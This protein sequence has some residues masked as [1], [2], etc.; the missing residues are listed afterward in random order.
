MVTVSFL[1][2]HGEDLFL[3]FHAERSWRRRRNAAALF[4]LWRVELRAS[5]ILG[6]GPGHGPIWRCSVGRPAAPVSAA[7]M[8]PEGRLL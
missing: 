3:R 6:A 7:V 2:L 8:Q 1:L 5:V 4:G